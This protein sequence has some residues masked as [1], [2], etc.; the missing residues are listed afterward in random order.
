MNTLYEL[1]N[2][3]PFKK[4][5]WAVGGGKGGTGQSLI[6]STL[7]IELAR[8]EKEVIL[9]DADL[10]GANLHTCLGIKNP[11]HTLAEFI[12]KNVPELKDVLID[13]SLEHLK[14][15]SGATD[16]LNIVNPQYTQKMRLINHIKKL[17]AEFII[18]DIGAGFSFNVIDF[19]L[20]SNSGILVVS[21]EP[22]SIENAYRFLK[23]SIL[24][25][26]RFATAPKEVKKQIKKVMDETVNEKFKTIYELIDLVSGV[27]EKSGEWLEKQLAKFRPALILNQ[28]KNK[29]E[30]FIGEAMKDITKKYLGIEMNYIGHV[31]YDE[32]VNQ[33]IKKYRPFTLEFPDCQAS[34]NVG[35]AAKKLIELSEK[36]T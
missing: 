13:T 20:L 1:K 17:S 12:N 19:F 5:I 16:L 4:K 29:D 35:L 10:G 9:V 7:A 30:I 21:P 34:I 18:I 36:R 15:L 32:K 11:A 28:V 25:K 6:S 14:L 23:N 33:S 27:D 22:T 8:M 24:R 26:L 2:G 3:H 31:P